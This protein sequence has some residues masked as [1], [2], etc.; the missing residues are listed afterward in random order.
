MYANRFEYLLEDEILFPNTY[1]LYFN[2]YYSED[3]TILTFPNCFNESV[4]NID[5]ADTLEHIN[6]GSKFN[7]SLKD[8][9][10][11]QSLKSI[12]FGKKYNLSIDTIVFPEILEIVALYTP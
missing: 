11:P 2:D 4:A 12:K 7:K 8:T 3:Y 1:D 10:F 9:R 6:F 5:F